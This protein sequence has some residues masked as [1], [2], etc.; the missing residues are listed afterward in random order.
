[1]ARKLIYDIKG[2]EVGETRVFPLAEGHSL[3]NAKAA[4]TQTA[5]RWKWKVAVETHTEEAALPADAPLVEVFA[6]IMGE[7]AYTN[8]TSIIVVARAA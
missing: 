6:R 7:T 3:F 4:I 5:K 1:M 8:G 2:M